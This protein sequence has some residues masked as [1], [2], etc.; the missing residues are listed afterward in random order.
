MWQLR[1]KEKA[2]VSPKRRKLPSAVPLLLI[3]IS[4]LHISPKGECTSLITARNPVPPTTR[5]FSADCSRASKS[6]VRIPSHSTRRLSEMLAATFS[7]SLHLN[8]FSCGNHTQFP[9]PCQGKRH[10]FLRKG[11]SHGFLSCLPAKG[12][13]KR[14]PTQA[15]RISFCDL[16]A[17]LSLAFAYMSFMHNCENVNLANIVHTLNSP[18][19]PNAIAP[20][21]PEFQSIL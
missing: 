11:T 2:P 18:H 5:R 8:S 19:F 20:K 7:L 17:A 14:N 1:V 12:T 15:A 16:P 9:S 6:S 13:T 21:N 3:S 10:T 4:S